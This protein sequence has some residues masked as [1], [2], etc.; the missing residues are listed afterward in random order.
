MLKVVEFWEAHEEVEKLME[1][2]LTALTALFHFSSHELSKVRH[3]VQRLYSLWNQNEIHQLFVMTASVSSITKFFA[4]SY[5][6]NDD[7]CCWFNDKFRTSTVMY[8]S[9]WP[10]FYHVYLS[11]SKE[12]ARCYHGNS[13][14][15]NDRT[16]MDDECVTI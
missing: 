11:L 8:Q 15:P 10:A 16:M 5:E 1:R 7:S 12:K 4:I 3:L 9:E 13:W 14:E 6:P 2:V